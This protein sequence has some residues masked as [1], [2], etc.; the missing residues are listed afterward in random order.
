MSLSDP[1][2][3]I[4]LECLGRLLTSP[5]FQR[6]P[7]QSA[8]LKYVVEQ[9]IAKD[10]ESLKEYQIGL[11]VYERGPAYDTRS[12]PI[13]RVEASRLRSKLLEYYDSQ[14]RED[15][16]RIMLPKGTYVAA[17]EWSV[18]QPEATQA[19]AAAPPPTSASGTPGAAVHRVWLGLGLAALLISAL[20]WLFWTRIR[21]ADPGST[22]PRSI[23][24][25]PFRDFSSTSGGSEVGDS[26]AEALSEE[27]SRVE[28]L[29]V[30]GR[31]STLRIRE[32]T[33]DMQTLGR[34][35]NVGAVLEG[36]IQ[37]SGRDVRVRARLID[38]ATGF[39]LWSGTFDRSSLRIFA[40]QDEIAR[41]IASTLKLQ[42]GRR[43]ESQEALTAPNR[44]A[45]R[46]L[47]MK[48]RQ[49]HRR[50]DPS[51]LMQARDIHL[52]AVK[53]DPAYPLAHSGLAHIDIT[54]VSDGLKPAAELRG[55][56]VS[57]IQRALAIDPGLSDAFSARV[58]LARDVD[59]DW[60]TVE[61]TCRDVTR[62]FPNAASIRAN[63][64]TA[65]SLLG[66]F[67]EAER[68]LR[69]AIRLDP[70][71]FGGMDGLAWM[72]YFSGRRDEALRQVEELMRVDPLFVGA[73]RTYA[74]ILTGS[75]RLIQ[76]KV[77]LEEKLKLSPDSRDLWAQLGY[78][79]GR[80]NDRQGALACLSS[81]RPRPSEVEH[82]L[83]WAG[84]GDADRAAAH[85]ER[86]LDRQ[87]PAAVE[88]LVDPAIPLG[89]H[90][91]RLRERAK[92]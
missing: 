87:D 91:R 78:V 9:T 16:V 70:L 4:V 76:A 27:L 79:R 73:N 88:I 17:F 37:S 15:A 6:A 34:R 25:L 28:G 49:L 11:R 54:I 71:W 44:L 39:Q 65:Y 68:E 84:L 38:V 64:G 89:A 36:S 55:E 42:L 29:S 69:A 12:D 47:F 77:F 63:C 83:V 10:L 86:A 23:A 22:M 18:G 56:I 92:L 62:L 72:L 3:V 26:L 82:A 90:T 45:A 43:R 48:A 31:T 21:P 40:V 33:A 50:G 52:Q 85:L 81:L 1:Q 80:L 35:L 8:F 57:S 67:D 19:V 2:S 7:R 60:R 58:R 66:R 13:V 53:T 59:A 24:I 20:V 61:T 74:R 75:G 32:Q 14:G 41:A 5:I 30:A 51:L 46:D